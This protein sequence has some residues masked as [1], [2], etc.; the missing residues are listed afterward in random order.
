MRS[1]VEVLFESQ[2][3]IPQ[4]SLPLRVLLEDIGKSRLCGFRQRTIFHTP[5]LTDVATRRRLICRIVRHL[6]VRHL[7][8]R[9]VHD[10]LKRTASAS[11]NQGKPEFTQ[12][13]LGQ[14]LHV[15]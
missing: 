9:R 4:E 7:V 6:T 2:F 11:S 3:W 1:E 14:N 5:Y 8:I 15:I 13:C 10:S 12:R